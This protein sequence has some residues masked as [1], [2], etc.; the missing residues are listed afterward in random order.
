M[1]LLDKNMSA[2]TNPP[3]PTRPGHPWPPS[4]NLDPWILWQRTLLSLLIGRGLLV[5]NGW[6]LVY[7]FE[8]GEWLEFFFSFVFFELPTTIN[9]H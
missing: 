7:Y 9:H 4:A 1:F 5:V 3:S 8:L 2:K 6:S